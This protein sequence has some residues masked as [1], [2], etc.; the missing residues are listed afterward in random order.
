MSFGTAL[1][2]FDP[3]RVRVSLETELM[4]RLTRELGD[5]SPSP[6]DHEEVRKEWFWRSQPLPEA[7]HAR[8]ERL[9]R[10]TCERLGVTRAVEI[11][12]RAGLA[13]HPNAVT[14]RSDEGPILIQLRGALL[15]HLDD[16]GVI[17]VLGHEIGHHLAHGPRSVQGI[18]PFF[19]YWRLAQGRRIGYRELAAAYCRAAELTADR[20]GLLACRDLEAVVRMEGMLSTE[21]PSGDSAVERLKRSREYAEALRVSRRR[22]R[23]DSHP[24]EAVR[25]YGIWLFSESDLF[26][27]LTGLGAGRVSIADVDYVLA[28]LAGPS[29]GAEDMG[30]P[31]EEEPCLVDRARDALESARDRAQALASAVTRRVP[32]QRASTTLPDADLA[33]AMA[34]LD[35]DPVEE[36]FRA[37]ER[38]VTDASRNELEERFAELERRAKDC[39]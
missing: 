31:P 23:G 13:H 21:T 27:D 7:Q 22:G 36:K 6:R 25:I 38:R 16:H 9:A 24:E 2:D 18:D 15:D 3:D 5:L 17:A 4:R 37:L 8:A 11:Y 34:E 10:V 12:Q 29:E 1:T 30:L 33:A 14:H 19:L 35:A 32:S 26:R 39:Q 28:R 20:I